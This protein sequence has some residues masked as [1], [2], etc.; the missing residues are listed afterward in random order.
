MDNIVKVKALVKEIQ[1]L[2]FIKKYKL[3]ILE[4]KKAIKKYPNISIFYNMLGLALSGLGRF[5]EAKVILQKGLS[6]N[7]NDLAIINNLAN[8]FKNTYNYKEAEELYKVSIS[9]KDDYLNAYVNFGNLK[10]DLN[11]FEEAIELYKKALVNNDKVPSIHYMLAMAYQ[12]LGNFKQ[13]ENFAK[14]TLEIDKK[15]TKADLLI[16]RSKKY[17]SKDNHLME[18]DEKI[19]NINL[20]SLEK[21]D[22]YFALSKAYEDLGKMDKCFEY[23]E[24]GNKLKRA[25]V[26]FDLN[27]E[28]KTFKDIKTIFSKINFNK[29]KNQDTNQKKIIFILGLPRSGTT[30]TEQIISAHSKVYGSG[31]LPYLTSIINKEFINDKILSASKINETLNDNSKISEIAKKYYFYL[32]NYL[33]DESYITDKAPLNFMWI[34]FIKILFP[35]AK[36]IHCKRDSKDNCVSLYKNVFEGGINFCY[37]QK[38]T[39]GYYNLYFDLM[40][41]W[42]ETLPDTFLDVDYEKIVSNPKDEIKK[43][44]KFCDLNWEDDC[45]N[46][47]KNKTPIK[48]ASVGQARNSIYTT[49][50]KSFSKYEVYLKELFTLLQKKSPN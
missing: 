26:N 29:Y 38:E 12:S 4:T 20:N 25:N 36:I 14:K 21:I 28:K 45:L 39:A 33:I 48:T 41:F 8:I 37:T 22:L 42:Q 31:E 47:S 15:Y 18:M 43:I 9:K 2:F 19:K 49:S 23:L 16:S 32:D 34:G 27:F 35:H 3:I 6:I 44:L 30:L 40:K 7:S 5:N 46:F 50:V 1:N 10:R 17:T 24:K 11:K 13:A